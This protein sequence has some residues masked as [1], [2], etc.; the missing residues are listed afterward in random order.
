MQ[1][2]PTQQ[3]ILL[4]KENNVRSAADKPK[5]RAHYEQSLADYKKELARRDT[6]NNNP[7]ARFVQQL[8]TEQ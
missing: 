5:L 6:P 8:E 3:A 4:A 2:T 7:F 1:L